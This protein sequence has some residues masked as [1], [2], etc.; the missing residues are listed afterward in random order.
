MKASFKYAPMSLRILRSHQPPT[1]RQRCLTEK[2]KGK[3]SSTMTGLPYMWWLASASIAAS[4]PTTTDDSSSDALDHK[5]HDPGVALLLE[6]R[7]AHRRAGALGQAAAM[8]A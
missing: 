2:E 5:L 1:A 4:V 6:L 8:H 7:L 3:T